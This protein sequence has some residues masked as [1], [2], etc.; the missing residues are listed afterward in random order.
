M[1][2]IRLIKSEINKIPKPPADKRIEYFD[3]ELPGFGLRVTESSKTYFVLGRVK[4]R[5][6]RYTIGKH[7]V[8][9]P[10]E[11]RKE[12]R[13]ALVDMSN[14]ID[15]N[16]KK[17]QDRVRG[18]TLKEALK[19]YFESKPK[20]R[21]GTKNTYECLLNEWLSDWMEKPIKDIGKKDVSTRHLKIADDRS[22]VTANNVMRTFRAIYNHAQAV[23]DGA[24]PESPTKILSRSKQWFHVGRRQT[25]IREHELN[26]WNKA[27]A[28][29]SNP[30]A[31]DVLLLLLLTGC[32][33]KEALTLQWKD[34]D[35]KGRTFTIRATVAKNHRA[36]TLPMS[37]AI[38]A[39]FKRREEARENDYVFPGQDEDGHIVELKRAVQAVIKKS[40]VKF[41]LHDLRRTFSGI[42]EQ[43]VSYAMLKRL[44]NHY[45][46]ND[47]TAGYLVIPTEQ[48]RDPMQKITNR[49]VAAMLKPE[50]QEQQEKEPELQEQP[51][52]KGKVIPLRARR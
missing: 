10:D 2:K 48:L 36:H 17:A 45:T 15:P 51:E 30:V 31:G 22:A 49:I 12:A 11:A 4:G 43:E 21:E 42:A 35:M 44:L 41:C 28:G 23:S 7:G 25:Y 46:G 52:E 27:V 9:T 19:E 18:I 6:K 40:K 16:E 32:R 50:E 13:Q 47:V 8:K 37:D 34:V 14:G 29:Y 38:F 3:T 1:G 26:K 33:E 39:V 5:L 24:L 20:L